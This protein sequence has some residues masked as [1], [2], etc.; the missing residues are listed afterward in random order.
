MKLSLEKKKEALDILEKYSGSNPYILYTK[1]AMFVQKTFQFNDFFGEFLLKNYKD[2]P[3]V[4]NKLIKISDWY[5]KKLQDKYRIDFTPQ[6]IRVTYVLGEMKEFYLCY[7]FYRGSQDKAVMEFIPKKAILTEFYPIEWKDV[8][9]DFDKYDL[10]SKNKNLKL[11]DHQKDGI[12]FM[13]SVKHC[14]NADSMGAGKTVQAIISALETKSSKILIVCPASLKTNWKREILNYCDENEVTIVN[15]QKWDLAKF[16]IMNYDILDNFYTVPEEIAYETIKDV[17]DKNNIV[18]HRQ[19]KWKVKPKYD[20]DGKIIAAGVPKMKTSISKELIQQSMDESQLFQSKFDV[21]IIDEAHRLSNSTSGR[22]KIIRD[23]LKRAKPD[24]TF[25]LTGTPITNNPINYFCMLAL[26]NH[27]VVSDYYNYVRRYCK[28]E[29]IYMK[30]EKWKW[31]NVFLAQNGYKWADVEKFPAVSKKLDIFL[32]KNAK[33][34]WKPNGCSHLDELME[35]TKNAYIRRMTSD[36]GDMVKKKIIEKE[37]DFSNEQKE[38]YDKVWDEYKNSQDLTKQ[39]DIEKYKAIIEG[40]VLRQ[41]V[42]DEMIDNTIEL[43]EQYLQSNEKQKIVIMCTFDNEIKKIKDYFKK[44]C[45]VY[46]GKMTTKAKDKAEVSFKTN[47]DVRVFIGNIEASGVGINLEVANVLIFNSFG[48]V[49]GN[50]KQAE[51]RI[52]RLTQVKD[53]TV[54]YQV[55]NDSFNKEMFD[56][57]LAKQMN[58]DEVIKKESDK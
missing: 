26:I 44:S 10:L 41:F 22:Y 49:S 23:L 17:D 31:T 48:W 33:Y 40:T 9:I 15:G 51:D 42:A 34:I 8:H 53:C 19:I 47:P 27:P 43:V 16:T 3:K 50:N 46:K 37:Y 58:I 18:T 24:Y 30:G 35:L 54:I 57:V 2:D 38:R 4:L 20:E 6:K 13:T 56:Y 7:L 55:Y 45:V 29:K 12:R 39:D 28:G 21:V 32:E 1:N 25:L 11:R 5:G 52:F 14:I 36:F